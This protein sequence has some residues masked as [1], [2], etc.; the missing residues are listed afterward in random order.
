MV[1][2][3]KIWIDL[4]N[5]S[6][7]LF[8]GAL[9]PELSDV[10]VSVTFRDRAETVELARS[11]G[12]N[13]RVIGRDYRGPIK[14]TLNMVYRTLDLWANVDRFDCALSFENGMSVFV[15]KLRRK[16]SIILCD[17]DLKFQQMTSG[18]Q[19]LESKIKMMADH[20]IV[21]RACYD[22]FA[23][24]VNGDR[25]IGYNGYKEDIYIA[26]YKPDPQFL[27]KIPFKKYVVVRPEALGSF[28]VNDKR[29]IVPELF[30]SFRKE[31][32][33]VIYLP[34]EREDFS[35]AK[36]FDEVYIPKNALNGLD[37]CYYADTVLTGSGT[38]AREA[39][40]MGKKAVSFF[41]SRAML[42]VDKR[43][44]NE[45]RIFHSRSSPE[46]ID[47][48]LSKQNVNLKRINNSKAV[49]TEIIKKISG[50]LS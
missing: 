33:D 10:E 5:P 49:K 50:C 4:I 21:P 25:V 26:D 39:A 8:F 15:A 46:I 27:K 19:D 22:N 17:N 12:I 6:H 13:G 31:H 14:K 18:I 37:I 28:Y 29:S 42:S 32:I 48:V 40:C 36:G 43:L 11:F 30:E 35:Y 44:M 7:A 1:E 45:G 9:I 2:N 16:K 24:H 47:Y 20:I 41:P 38:M 34:R 3:N 23:K